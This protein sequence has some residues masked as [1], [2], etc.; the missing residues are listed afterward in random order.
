[1][2]YVLSCA[3]RPGADYEAVASCRDKN[4]NTGFPVNLRFINVF[5]RAHALFIKTTGVGRG[6]WGVFNL[7]LIDGLPLFSR[8][9]LIKPDQGVDWIWEV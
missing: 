4:K 5:H 9:L 3:P 7:L 6:V 8:H 2:L 1:M